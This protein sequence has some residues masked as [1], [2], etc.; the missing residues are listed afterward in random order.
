M[1]KDGV[2]PTTKTFVSL[3]SALSKGADD[4]MDVVVEVCVCH[5]LILTQLSLLKCSLLL[6]RHIPDVLSAMAHL[7]SG[8]QVRG[9][10]GQDRRQ[11]LRHLL[12]GYGCV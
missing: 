2:A 7:C 10:G 1:W 11:A 5:W 9:R 4:A 6:M 3:I 12:S 8:H